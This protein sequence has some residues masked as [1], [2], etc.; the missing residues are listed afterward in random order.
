MRIHVLHERKSP[1]LH[2]KLV[3]NAGTDHVYVRVR[4]RRTGDAFRVVPERNRA[5]DAFYHPFCYEPEADWD[6]QLAA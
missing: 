1:D 3:W 4:D 6:G 5:L 2:V